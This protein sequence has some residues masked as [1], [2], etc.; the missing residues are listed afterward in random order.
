VRI[1]LVSSNGFIFGSW[2]HLPLSGDLSSSMRPK[3][4]SRIELGEV[5]RCSHSASGCVSLFI[6]NDQGFGNAGPASN[7][8]MG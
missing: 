6:H 8:T 1:K 4:I 5:G 3:W 7:K 2:G